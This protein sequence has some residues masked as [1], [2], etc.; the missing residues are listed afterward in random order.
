MAIFNSYVKLPEGIFYLFS[1]SKASPD[2]RPD[3]PAKVLATPR[4]PS[5]APAAEGMLDII[6][7]NG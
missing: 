4:P 5:L 1:T 7:I 3:A 2:K 6:L